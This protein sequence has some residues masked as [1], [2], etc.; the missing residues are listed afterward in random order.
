MIGDEWT[1]ERINDLRANKGYDVMAMK[2]IK[3]EK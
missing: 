2:F 3:L 1:G